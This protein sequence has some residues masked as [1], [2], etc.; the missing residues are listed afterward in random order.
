M[1]KSRTGRRV[2]KTRITDNLIL[3]IYYDHINVITKRVNDNISY[4]T[5]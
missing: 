2:G 3:G 5:C 4:L 1:H